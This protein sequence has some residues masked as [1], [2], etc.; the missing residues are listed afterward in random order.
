MFIDI[1]GVCTEPGIGASGLLTVEGFAGVRT[2]GAVG[3][4]GDVPLELEEDT[5]REGATWYGCMAGEAG[6]HK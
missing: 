6:S 1:A 4:F 2:W 3:V 5:G